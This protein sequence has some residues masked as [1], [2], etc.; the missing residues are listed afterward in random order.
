M[1]KQYI[2][3][4][5]DAAAFHC[6]HCGVYSHQAWKALYHLVR[7]V[8]TFFPGCQM[9]ICNH[10]H[11][12]TIWVDNKQVWPT[13]VV[14]PSPNEDVNEDIKQVYNEART[15]SSLSPRCA[16]AL[17]R[18]C[19]QLLCQQLGT[20]GMNL[21]DD[22]RVL[23][24]QGL[25]PTVQQAL[26]VLRVIGNKAVHPGNIDLMDDRETVMQLFEVFN[27]VAEDCL[28]RPR[29][30]GEFYARLPSSAQQQIAERDNTFTSNP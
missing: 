4:A 7:E 24:K 9:A 2:A 23:V 14:G 25:S 29:Q 19:V 16:A 8:P 18:L 3:P 6:P 11:D 21:N 1:A 15:V 26:D 5:K 30:V 22:I 10:C 13:D 17:L 20:S 12:F 28:T 27:F